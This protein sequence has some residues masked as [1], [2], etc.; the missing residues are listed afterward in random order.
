MEK[1]GLGRPSYS[2]ILQ[3]W[4]NDPSMNE[5]PH[6][7]P[8]PVTVHESEPCEIE[9]QRSDTFFGQRVLTRAAGLL[10]K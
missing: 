3:R 7:F 1:E 6:S 9:N 2:V 4:G 8:R 10:P 5:F